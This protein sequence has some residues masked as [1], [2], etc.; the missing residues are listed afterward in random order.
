MKKVKKIT[1][2]IKKLKMEYP[3][4]FHSSN[5]DPFYVLIS[6]ILSQRTKDEQT[7]KAAKQVFSRFKTPKQ[8][9]KANINTIKKLIKPSGFYNVKA[10]RI[11]DVSRIIVNEYNGKVPD[12]INKL[13]KLPGVGYKTAACVLVYA[14]NKPEVPVDVHVAVMAQRLGLTKEKSPDKIR[15]DLM[16]R[17]PKRYWLDINELFVRHGQDVC[18]TRKPKCEICVISDYCDY[19]QRV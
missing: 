14:F 4:F 6:T 19:Y 10:K 12:D 7:L 13:V 3:L 5:K 18:L 16:K 8:I 17:I 9:A 2:I 11:K 1:M 15:L